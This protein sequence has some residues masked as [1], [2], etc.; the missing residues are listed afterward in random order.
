ME[1]RLWRGKAHRPRGGSLWEHRLWRAL[2]KRK[3]KLPV[4]RRTYGVAMS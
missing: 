1:H 4:E 3:P 2:R